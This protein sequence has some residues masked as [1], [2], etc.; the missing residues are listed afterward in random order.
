[1]R[2]AVLGVTEVRDDDGRPVPLGGGRLRALLT[3]LAVNAGRTVTPEELIDEVWAGD[4]PADAPGALQA[5]V[6][7]LRR[8]LGRDAIAFE[9][10]GYRLTAASDAVDLHRFERLLHE[11]EAALTDGDPE[12]AA[13]TLGRALALWRGPA[14][15]D[16]PDRAAATRPEALRRTA[17]R[18]RAEADL[19]RGRAATALPVLEQAVA[20]HP[21]D[22]AF[23]AQLLRALRATGR[24]ADALAAYDE[25]RTVLAD[26]LGADPGPEL[27]AL[28]AQLLQSPEDLTTGERASDRPVNGRPRTPQPQRVHDQDWAPDDGRPRIEA[29]DRTPAHDGPTAARTRVPPS[30]AQP[31][32]PDRPPPPA[33]PGNLRARLTSFVGR[34]DDLRALTAALTTAP[35]ADAAH[36][37]GRRPGADQPAPARLLTLTGPGGSGKTRLSVEAAEAVQE[38][39]PD[40][41]WLAELAPL[42]D[43][44][45]VPHAVLSALGRRDTTLRTYARDQLGD[46]AAKTKTDGEDPLARIVEHCGPRRLL[47]VLD[48]CEHLVAAAAHLAAEVLARCPGVT[49]LAT[50]REPLGVPGEVMRPVEPLPPPTAFRLFA[51]R[52]AAV[53]PGAADDLDAAAVAEICRRLDGLPLAIE[54][55]A[56]RLR[57]LSPRQIAD[58]LDDRFRLLTGGSRT[59]L[60]RQQTLRAVVDWSWDLLTEPE[61]DTLR[62]L[63][64][65]AGGCTLAAAEAVCGPDAMDAV[66]GLVD[67]SLVVADHGL[68]AGTRYRLLET[69]HEYAAERAGERPGDLA[70]AEARHTAWVR[71][72]VTEADPKLRGADQMHWL[73]VLE[74]ELDNVRAALHRTVEAGAE[75]DALAIA[76]RMGWFWWLR[77]YRDEADGWL[78]RVAAL[79]GEPARPPYPSQPSSGAPDS[80]HAGERGEP[81]EP[82]E[83]RETGA[84]AE[85]ALFGPAHPLHWP[86]TDLSLLRFFVNSDHASDEQW[87]SEESRATATALAAAYRAGGPPAAR[88]PGLLWPFTLY[89]LGDTAGIRGRMDEVVANCRAHG[90]DWEVAAAM[91]FRT[92]ATVDTPGGL[93]DAEAQ[94]EEVRAL[95]DRIG[96]RWIRAQIHGAGGEIAVVRGRYAQARADFEA[97]YRLGRELAAYGE[98]ALLLGRLAD[99]AHRTGDD[100]QA[101]ELLDRAEAEAERYG[102]HDART[103]LR[104]LRA[105]LELRHG[106]V[107]AA[108]D[109]CDLAAGHASDGTPPPMFYVLL[110]T[111]DARITAAEGDPATALAGLARAARMALDTNCTEQ[112][113]AAQFDAAASVLAHSGAAGPAL[114]VARAADTVR[115]VVHG[116]LPRTVPEQEADDA[117]RAL[118]AARLGAD[119]H[120]AAIAAGDRLDTAGW[121]RCWRS[122]PSRPAGPDGEVRPD[123]RP[124]RAGRA[125]R[126]GRAGDRQ[127]SQGG[128]AGIACGSGRVGDGGGGPTM[129]SPHVP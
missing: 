18:L 112:V 41:V 25:A 54:L 38:A 31:G 28:R 72:L 42:D 57:A 119:E 118:A 90:G 115:D 40:G 103:Y 86:R 60:P 121:W 110:L 30:P 87:S 43:P 14:L 15:A 80:S 129:H 44:A 111:L 32:A 13:V 74:T 11:G 35:A 62:R 116:H 24:T 6:G 37:G 70:A 77:N 95:D 125:R 91:M 123:R 51:E 47:L 76:L 88:F 23:R 50:S 63:S 19:A 39:F 107:A 78:E 71:A 100:E 101:A 92:H 59:L 5:L 113:V 126:T 73:A 55:A 75:P 3:V 128:A 33:R 109:L 21:L 2:Y 20:D 122:W 67:K 61:R 46:G 108:R 85:G 117:V 17:L 36:P 94:W 105:E 98:G 81:G 56:A 93:A 68:P 27:R 124:N 12:A 22:E 26:T 10:G 9:P 83:A 82:G 65:F 127:H 79:A 52:A 84:G 48:N 1:M 58:R 96:D 97:A 45:A 8:A 34:E 120:A 53:R 106:G 64:V 16:L 29:P 7:R 102:V 69:I 66:S 114:T 99:L 89:V 49:V 104:Y 4:P